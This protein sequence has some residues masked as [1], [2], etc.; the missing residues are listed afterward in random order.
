MKV[1]L[2]ISG[3]QRKGDVENETFMKRFCTAFSNADFYYHTWNETLL[4]EE[5]NII[6]TPE[7][8]L[9]YHSVFH[10]DEYGGDYLDEK[11]QQVDKSHAK[12]NTGTKQ[13]IGHAILVQSLP[14]DYDIIIR[15]RWD[16]YVSTKYDWQTAIENCYNENKIY[17]YAWRPKNSKEFHNPYIMDK[18]FI[19]YPYMI[20]DHVII[21]RPSDIDPNSVFLLH[22]EK[23]LL[24]GE[25]GWHQVFCG[26]K[27][28]NH[29]NFVGGLTKY[30]AN[31]R[32]KISG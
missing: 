3:G 6:T 1:A 7:P 22:E 4:F 15:T 30:D 23:K 28:N 18:E 21:H 24:P 25:W 27:P 14:D 29:V 5:P 17:G 26:Q 32:L 31:N 10:T 11:R 19:R 16:C 9:G 2:C 20:A 8:H 12:L 13:I